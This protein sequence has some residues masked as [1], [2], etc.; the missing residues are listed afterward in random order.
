MRTRIA[1]ILTAATLSVAAAPSPTRDDGLVIL[2]GNTPFGA[3]FSQWTARWWQFAL[4]FP[5]D[6]NPLFDA[7]VSCVVGQSGPVWFLMHDFGSGTPVHRTCSVPEGTALFFPI[8]NVVDINV[9]S[10]S[11]AELRAET[12]PCLDA[13]TELR[14]TVDGRSVDVKKSK[15]R[16]RSVVFPVTFPD[17]NVL[18]VPATTYSPVIDDGY[19]VMLAPMSVGTHTFAFSGSST[20]CPLMGGPFAVDVTYDLT[21]V[22]VTLR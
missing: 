4:S 7:S 6:A 11:P 10:Q 20:G 2:P 17:G 19:Y 12:A 22:P 15:T 21:V 3:V 13:V 16:V 1:A 8:I 9:A 18:G 14:L 5:A